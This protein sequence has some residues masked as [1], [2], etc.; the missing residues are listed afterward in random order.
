M[1]EI[2]EDRVERYRN[3]LDRL[4]ER[5]DDLDRWSRDLKVLLDSKKDRRA[6]KKTFQEAIEAVTD[7][8]A[9]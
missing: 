7:L 9:M 3:K 4:D 2:S 1:K 8:C 5:L 6:V